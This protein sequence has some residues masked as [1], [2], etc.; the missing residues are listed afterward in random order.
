M[1]MLSCV[2][3][4]ALH[5]FGLSLC[6][7]VCKELSTHRYTGY[8]RI[9]GTTSPLLWG[10]PP[11]RKTYFFYEG[12]VSSVFFVNEVGDGKRQLMAWNPAL[13]AVPSQKRVL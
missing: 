7:L 3:L 9:Q 10:T 1:G 4:P 5:I 11:I 8:M 13:G 2:L 12:G 6:R